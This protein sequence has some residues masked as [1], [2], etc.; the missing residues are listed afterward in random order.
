[1]QAFSQAGIKKP[2]D[3]FGFD[4]ALRLIDIIEHHVGAG[5]RKQQYY[6]S[7]N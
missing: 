5:T 6:K 3:D 4:V 1:M 2:V 7:C